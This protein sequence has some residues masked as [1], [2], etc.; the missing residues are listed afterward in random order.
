MF[1]DRATSGGSTEGC[2]HGSARRCNKNMAAQVR[3]HRLKLLNIV[4]VL[5]FQWPQLGF[6][7]RP[8]ASEEAGCGPL[9]MF[10]VM[11]MMLSV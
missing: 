9:C 8:Q 2:V 3:L 7:W 11:T 4:K 6:A 5:S 1:K 10:V